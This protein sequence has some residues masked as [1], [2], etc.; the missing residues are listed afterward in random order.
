MN[1]EFE[2]GPIRPPSEAV[3]LLIRVTRNCP[4]NKCAFCRSYK[5]EQFELRK[6]EDIQGD[7]R[8]AAAIAEE[9]RN[10]SLREGEGGLVTDKIIYSIFDRYGIYNDSFRT[11]AY[12][13]YHGGKSVFIQD[14]DSLVMKL[15][16][17][18]AVIGLISPE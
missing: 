18:T 16:D 13:L 1:F 15:A 6:L 2:Q 17:L 8:S 9:I 14:A 7:I 3:S 11:I 12:W 10:I 4:W 5:D